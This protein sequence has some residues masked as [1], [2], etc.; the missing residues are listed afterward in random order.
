MC[1]FI[2]YDLPQK[3][4]D[5]KSPGSIARGAK[6]VDISGQLVRWKVG[7]FHHHESGKLIYG[8]QISLCQ[9]DEEDVEHHLIELPANAQNVRVRMDQIPPEYES[10][11]KNAA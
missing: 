10:A 6:E 3:P 5:S 1:M 7:E 2:T 8:V 4:P 11:L 9:N